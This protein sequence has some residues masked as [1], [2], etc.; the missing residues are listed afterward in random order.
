MS[1][2][3]RRRAGEGS[4]RSYETAAGERWLVVYGVPDPAT[5]KRRQLL[6]RGF[7][8]Q[9]A[10]TRA[11]R[12]ALVKV[13]A[14]QHLE[15]SKQPLSAYLSTW[16]DG[17]RLEPST[18][19]SYRKNVRLHVVPRIGGTPLAAVTGT[20]LT[21]L[22][23][24]LQRDGRADSKGGLSPR[25]VRYV[26][27]I[28]QRALKDA[29]RDGRLALNPAERAD[30][31]TVR[32][33]AAPEMITWDAA[34]LRAFLAWTTEQRDELHAAWV[35]LA[36][37]GMRRGELLALRWGDVDLDRRVLTV[38]RS[39]GAI[40]EQGQRERLV[41]GPPKSGRARVVDVDDA[42]VAVLRAQRAHL[43]GVSLALAREDGRV[44]PALDGGPRHPER[45]SRAF[46]ARVE[47]YR[48]QLGD[49]A[50]PRLRLHDLRHT[51][52]TVALTRRVASDATAGGVRRIG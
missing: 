28:L 41:E 25:T 13:D 26:H 50:P 23:A 38:R 20:M 18:V 8:T 27:T 14:G 43:A 3:R 45:F 9:R 52:A 47:R 44:V 16:L 42:T 30:P 46:V 10:A 32:E 34:Q 2:T 31:P 51:H 6:R 37:T 17:L 36:M 22:Y 5:G 21:A 35:L 29:V 39:L 33:A 1:E 48:G 40:R 11:L 4:V 15:P 7:T 19:A 24:D 12:E 49:D